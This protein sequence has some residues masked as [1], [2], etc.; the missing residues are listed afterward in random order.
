[1]N[2]NYLR[3]RIKTFRRDYFNVSSKLLKNSLHW[4]LQFS[5]DN[6]K[7]LYLGEIHQI[8]YLS[9]T[10]KQQRKYIELIQSKSANDIDISNTYKNLDNT[11]FKKTIRL[12]FL[13]FLSPISFLSYWARRTA[14]IFLG[15]HVQFLISDVNPPINLKLNLK[16]KGN[17]KSVYLNPNETAIF[18]R[19]LV[20]LKY[21]ISSADN[22]F[23]PSLHVDPGAGFTSEYTIPLPYAKNSKEQEALL[24]LPPYCKSLQLEVAHGDI[25][26]QIG[27]ISIIESNFFHA[28]W[29]LK[30]KHAYGMNDVLHA[31]FIKKLPGVQRPRNS[32]LSYPDWS[33]IYTRLSPYD[34]N[35]IKQHLNTFTNPPLF[36]IFINT[37]NTNPELLKLCFESLKKQIFSRWEILITCK[38]PPDTHVASLLNAYE[39]GDDRIKIIIDKKTA[40]ISQDISSSLKQSKG[41]YCIF[42]EYKDLLSEHALYLFACYFQKHN[43]AKLIYSDYDHIDKHGQL[44]KPC[45]KPDWNYDFFL[46]KNFLQYIITY[47]T[48]FL[49]KTLNESF[50]NPFTQASQLNIFLVEKLNPSGILHIPYVLLHHYEA[51]AEI[52]DTYDDELRHDEEA[53]NAHLKRTKQLAITKP[54]QGGYWVKRMVPEPKP[55]VSLIV[56]TRNRVA[57]LSNCIHGLLEKTSYKNVEIII[58]DNGS[59]ET[60]TLSFLDSINKKEHVKVLRHPPKF[61]FSELNNLAVKHASGE[62]I[63]LINNDISII[64]PHWLDEMMGHIIRDQVGVVGAKLLYENDT[65][66]HAGVTV[67]LGGVAGHHFRHEPRHARG[68]GDRLLLCQELSCVTAACLLTKKTLYKKVGGLDMDNV[69]IA[70]N[71]VDFCL[72]VKKLGLKVIWTP[73][74]ELYHLESASR[75]S[76]LSKENIRRW[77]TEYMFMREKWKHVLDK[78]PFYNSNLTI[79]HEDFS[80]DHPPRLIHPWDE[81]KYIL[82]NKNIISPKKV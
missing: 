37:D 52:S 27:H 39:S 67:G 69:R 63:C 72:K 41:Q 70:F 36:S 74:A 15:R 48:A 42:L 51:D 35:A 31:L 9:N 49:K 82:G 54:I 43:N 71:D 23:E 50:A 30:T 2:Y 20:I 75:G 32:K 60:A 73:F 21:S 77:N 80:L 4:M 14:R 38:E 44:H 22:K 10:I 64:E 12:F 81:Y 59:E 68:Y 66:Q 6:F 19:G 57:L 56:L 46:G 5:I 29:Y 1:M 17:G 8:K 47:E 25:D 65:I 61:N 11:N 34:K 3:L 7:Y 18:P 28:A 58:V 26:F 40:S 76:D 45:F 79:T 55:M 62:Y 16:Y 78:D 13:I 33:N 53:L 24:E